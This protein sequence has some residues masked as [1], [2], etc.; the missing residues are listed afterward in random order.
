[1][2]FENTKGDI[3]YAKTIKETFDKYFEEETV[4]VRCE[5]CGSEEKTQQTSIALPP[6]ILVV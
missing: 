4:Q 2:H 1:M 3:V 5:D 6:K